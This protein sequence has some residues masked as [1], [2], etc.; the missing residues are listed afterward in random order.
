MLRISAAILLACAFAVLPALAAEARSPAQAIIFCD[1]RGCRP[2]VATPDRRS[3]TDA[4]GNRA[5]F[6]GMVDA[7]AWSA[8]VPAHIAHAVVRMESNYNPRVRGAAGEWGIGQIFCATAR[9]VGFS[10]RCGDLADAGVNLRYAMT[11][12]R[13]A[14]DKG[15]AGCAGVSLYNLGVAARPRCT[16]YGRTVMRLAGR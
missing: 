9:G 2:D 5:A 16:A 8:G 3:V 14:I 15:G 7:A 13:L 10:G 11:Y 6:G 12:L 1:D 4:N